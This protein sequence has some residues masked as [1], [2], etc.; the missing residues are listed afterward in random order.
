MPK[1]DDSKAP[2]IL[3]ASSNL[4]GFSFILV[5]TIQVLGLKSTTFIDEVAA[6]EVVLFSLSSLFAFM[7]LRARTDKRSIFFEDVAAV[8]FF[9]GLSILSISSI[10]LVFALT[11]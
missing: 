1:N 3:D 7:S 6:I 4:V 9:A 2:D 8:I 5:G 10:F 11:R